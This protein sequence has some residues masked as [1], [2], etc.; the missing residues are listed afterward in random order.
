[1]IVGVLNTS[2]PFFLVTWAQQTLSSSMGVILTETTPFFSLLFAHYLLPGERMNANKGMGL[3]FGFVGVVC[4]SVP[5]LRGWGGLSRLLPQAAVIMAA[6]CYA[7]CLI[8]LKRHLSHLPSLYIAGSTLTVGAIASLPCVLWWDASSL[9]LWRY[10]GA[11]LLMVS[12]LSL[13][14]TT[15][16][17]FLF[18]RL[19]ESW[20]PR[21]SLV[22]YVMPLVGT[23]LGV[24][25]LHEQ[26]SFLFVLGGILILLGMLF[27]QQK[28]RVWNE[29]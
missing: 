28:I 18:Y 20:G 3:V 16:A 27:V 26:L 19:V 7:L 8:V 25:F 14:H 29:V 22:A 6:S 2:L 5:S 23:T 24:L 4:L 17:Y 15:V 13:V 10:S 11:T 9:Q 12:V 1:C 21:T